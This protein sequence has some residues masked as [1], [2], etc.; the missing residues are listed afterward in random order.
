MLIS[1]KSKIKGIGD[2]I[3]GSV[4]EGTLNIGDEIRFI[5]SNVTAKIKS[6]QKYFND[7][8]QAIPGDHVAMTLKVSSKT[9]KDIIVGDVACS[10]K[11]KA[12]RSTKEITALVFV[13][14]TE[15]VKRIRTGYRSHLFLGC[16]HV[17]CSVKEI[18]WKIGAKSTNNK[19]VDKPMFIE[20]GDQSQIVLTLQKAVAI[21]KYDDFKTLGRFVSVVGT[22]PV[23]YGKVC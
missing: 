4:L 22:S 20:P 13:C 7:V 15:I 12:I 16:D 8:K 9:T 21:S 6:L 5:P 11:E 2:V 10:D 14:G 19:K 3:H 1:G 17:S 23:F 18:K